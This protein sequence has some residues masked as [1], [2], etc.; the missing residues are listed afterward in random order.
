MQPIRHQRVGQRYDQT[1]LTAML[2]QEA[3]GGNTWLAAVTNSDGSSTAGD[4]YAMTR[5]SFLSYITQR[6]QQHEQLQVS[7]VLSV[8]TT[9]LSGYL[10]V[11]VDLQRQAD[12]LPAQTVRAVAMLSCQNQQIDAWTVGGT[13]NT[14]KVANLTGDALIEDTLRQR[15][16]H[17]NNVAMPGGICPADTKHIVNPAV[18][19]A[20]GK[21]PVY[22]VIGQAD[23]DG[24]LHLTT[25]ND[26]GIG[27]PPVDRGWE[28]FKV[29]WTSDPSYYGPVLVRGGQLGGTS[30]LGFRTSSP[31]DP[32]LYFTAP[33][34]NMFEGGY[35]FVNA[36]ATGCYAMQVDGVNFREFIM[37]NVK[38]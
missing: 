3:T 13:V 17:V 6:H 20:F 8:N 21:G 37:I 19:G 9:W 16:L 1:T 33:H 32:D 29:I 24:T 12:D 10:D 36:N 31:P 14:S 5:Q 11:V 15:P 34:G 30:S 25:N 4:T 22:V 35:I 7:K 18:A 38:P 23:P 2:A 26:E 27:P 28:A